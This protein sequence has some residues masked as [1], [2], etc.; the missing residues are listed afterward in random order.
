MESC[1]T[2]NCPMRHPRPCKYFN[3]YKRCKFRSF[4]L[5]AHEKESPSSSKCNDEETKEKFAAL[6]DHIK[7]L[8]DEIRISDTKI[9]NAENKIELLENKLESVKKKY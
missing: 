3:I 1:E 5:F 4:C 2:V 7:G 6:E 8:E 9:R